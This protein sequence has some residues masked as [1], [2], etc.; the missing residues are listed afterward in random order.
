MYILI[1]YIYRIIHTGLIFLDNTYINIMQLIYDN[2]HD[3]TR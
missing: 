3:S 1:K 2:V